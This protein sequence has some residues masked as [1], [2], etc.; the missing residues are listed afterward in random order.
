MLGEHPNQPILIRRALGADVHAES[1]FPR[2]PR[3]PGWHRERYINNTVRCAGAVILGFL[4]T[5]CHSLKVSEPS[6]TA[7]EQLLLSTAAD[8]G[9][10]DV[11]LTPLRG[12]KVFLEERYFRS[13]DEDYVLGAIRELL[14]K[15]GAFL[16][17]T[18]DE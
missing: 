9:L 15:N 16:V 1:R 17:R 13:Y 3:F 10:K 5:G 2:E 11:D 12:K 14:L 18:F 6:R 7:A 8:R 4:I